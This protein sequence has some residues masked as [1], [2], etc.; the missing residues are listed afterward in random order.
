MHESILSC[1]VKAVENDGD[2]LECGPKWIVAHRGTLELFKDRLR[3]GN[4][5]I[6]Y[7]NINQAVLTSFQSPILRIPGHVLAVKTE[8]KTYHFGVN[9]NGYWAGNLPFDVAR[10]KE[11]L[12]LSPLSLFGR[13]AF[14]LG[15]AYLVWRALG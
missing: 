1:A 14:L 11:R 15:I 13:M 10:Q 8:T 2:L 3:C 6:R 12:K 5:E 9:N 4:W 7:E